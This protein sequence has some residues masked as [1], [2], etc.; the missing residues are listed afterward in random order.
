MSNIASEPAPDRSVPR[1]VVYKKVAESELRLFVFNPS[2]TG[3]LR[4]LAIVIHGGGWRHGKPDLMF[5]FCR[6]LASRGYVT[7][8]VEYR[9]TGGGKTDVFDC[10]ADVRSAVRWAKAHGGELGVDPRRIVLIGES[11]GGHLAACVALIDAFDDPRDDTS[12]P[13]RPAALVLFNPIVD[14]TPPDGWDVARFGGPSEKRVAARSAEFSPIAFVRASLPPTLVLHGTADTITPIENSRRFV[15]KMRDAGNT[16]ALLEVPG[17]NHAFVVPG[18]GD[19]DAARISLE[20]T[21][22]FLTAQGLEPAG[23]DTTPP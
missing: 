4:P 21:V 6:D 10:I 8:A 15:T 5:R 9:L 16:A 22:K 12:I 11:A 17:R 7:A 14:T 19:D 1:V 3:G 2:D 18:F 13:V 20:A 23:M